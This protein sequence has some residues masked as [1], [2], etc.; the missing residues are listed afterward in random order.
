MNQRSALEIFGVIVVV[1]MISGFIYYEYFLPKAENKSKSTVQEEVAGEKDV[2]EDIFKN[3]TYNLKVSDKNKSTKVTMVNGIAEIDKY[4]ACSLGDSAINQTDKKGV[5]VV[6]C[7]YSASYTD[8]FLVAFKNLDGTPL[9]T[10]VVDIRNHPELESR[11]L[12][13]VEVGSVTFDSSDIIEAEVLV[14][15]ASFGNAPEYQKSPTE[16]VAVKYQLTNQ[17]KLIPG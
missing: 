5:A 10:D 7:N 13:K 6:Y 14:V 11:D 4:T 8:A 12:D 17:G 1:L 15:P 2:D 16:P 9:Q 3:I